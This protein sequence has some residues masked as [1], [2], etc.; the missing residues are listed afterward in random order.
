[1]EAAETALVVNGGLA[2]A[3]AENHNL[4]DVVSAGDSTCQPVIAAVPV[5]AVAPAGTQ[6]K[7]LQ[8]AGC[9]VSD[10]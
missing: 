2:A 1:M 7:D 6:P 3:V 5:A 8:L 4:I 9:M 10:V